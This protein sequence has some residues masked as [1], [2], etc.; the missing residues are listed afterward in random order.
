MIGSQGLNSFFATVYL[1]FCFE[2]RSHV[3]GFTI[4]VWILGISFKA[5]GNS[6]RRGRA[7]L[8]LLFLFYFSQNIIIGENI[9]GM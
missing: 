2:K 3:N 5:P 4:L 9:V 1:L 7:I 6:S 8:T